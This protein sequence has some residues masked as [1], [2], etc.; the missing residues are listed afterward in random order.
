[1]KRVLIGAAMLALAGCGRNDAPGAPGGG[2]TG[3]DG[4]P[5]MTIVT[6]E[7]RAEIRTSGSAAANLP[8]GIPAYPGAESAGGMTITGGSAEGGGAMSSFRTSDSPAQVLEF[9]AAAAERAGYRVEG[10]MTMGP[11][12]A[13]TAARDGG[14]FH[15]NAIRGPEGTM[16]Q[17]IASRE[18]AR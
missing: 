1:M 15:V 7:G 11:N 2:T 13:L 10:R 6:N 9:Y 5:A 18:G 16:V 3:A 4:S 14:G 12:A 17:L 8:D